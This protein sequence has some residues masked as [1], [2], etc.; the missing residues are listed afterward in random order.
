[1]KYIFHIFIFLLCMYAA[2]YLNRSTPSHSEQDAKDILTDFNRRTQTH[3]ST[4]ILAYLK[5]GVLN[6]SARLHME[7]YFTGAHG[8][9]TIKPMAINFDKSAFLQFLQHILFYARD[10]SVDASLDALKYNEQI[11]SDVVEFSIR[12]EGNSHS[13]YGLKA[14]MHYAGTSKCSMIVIPGATNPEIGSM[15][16]RTQLVYTPLPN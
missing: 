3:S 10:Y 5:D 7:F 15:S 13:A 14:E 12:E 16:C 2:F 4:M 8:E 9:T 1:M 11:K 6:N